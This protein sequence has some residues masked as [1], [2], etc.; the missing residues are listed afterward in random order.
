[1]SKDKEAMGLCMENKAIMHTPWNECS[2]G[3]KIE[4]LRGELINARERAIWISQNFTHIE[5]QLRRLDNHQHGSN[6]VML[7]TIRNAECGYGAAGQ[8]I[9]RQYDPLA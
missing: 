5:S 8:A 3:Q 7:V 4:R 2:I 1:M 9:E 6:G